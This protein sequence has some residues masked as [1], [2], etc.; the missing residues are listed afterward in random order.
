V[1]ATDIALVVAAV[2][3]AVLVIAMIVALFR[4]LGLI[5]SAT[6]A[7]DKATD[8]TINLL[9]DANETVTGVN[10]ELARID[11][12]VAGVQSITHT[13]DQLVGVLHATISNP[14]VKGA[15]YAVGAARTVKQLRG[16]E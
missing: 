8:Q 11:T 4:L 13:T 14:L 1:T 10:V 16:G 6:E 5:A 12:I 2:F 3:W 9:S 15:A 7:V